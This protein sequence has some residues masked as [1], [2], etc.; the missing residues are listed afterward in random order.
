LR[1]EIHIQPCSDSRL[2][3]SARMAFTNRRISPIPDVAA[4]LAAGLRQD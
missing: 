2:A 3:W 1:G 4:T